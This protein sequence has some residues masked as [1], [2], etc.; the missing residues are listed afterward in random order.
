MRCL[1]R[2]A[3]RLALRGDVEIVLPVHQNPA[4]AEALVPELGRVDGVQLTGPLGYAD[5]IA[6]LSACD[7]V[8]TDSGGVQEEAAVLGKPVL[9]LRRTTERPE[10][11]RHGAAELV[12]TDPREVYERAV[13]LLT[14]RRRPLST[15]PPDV[16]GG[17]DAAIRIVERLMHDLGGRKAPLVDRGE[18]A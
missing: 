10:A 7:L 5:F 4:V 3:A 17:G 16:F 1:A 11:I 15:A 9:V 2:A 14:G 18:R 12:G 13:D 6:T 8:L